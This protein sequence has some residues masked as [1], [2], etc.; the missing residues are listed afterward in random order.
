MSGLVA[1]ALPFGKVYLG[2]ILSRILHPSFSL[3]QASSLYSE[4]RHCSRPTSSKF[5]PLFGAGKLFVQ[6]VTVY[7]SKI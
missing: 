3:R 4:L 5:S 1:D 7:K 2:S 6:M